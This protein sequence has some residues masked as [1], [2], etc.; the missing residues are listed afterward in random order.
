M[1]LITRP[2]ITIARSLTERV[3]EKAMLDFSQRIF[4]ESFDV[5]E[6]LFAKK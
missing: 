3:Y 6:L 4:H 2:Q 5:K 1:K